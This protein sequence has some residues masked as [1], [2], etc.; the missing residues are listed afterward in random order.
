MPA[1]SPSSPT[2]TPKPFAPDLVEAPEKPSSRIC[3]GGCGGMLDPQF[4]PAA[5]FDSRIISG[6]NEWYFED[7]CDPCRERLEEAETEADKTKKVRQYLANTKI[8]PREQD[9]C[10][11]DLNGAG[12]DALRPHVSGFLMGRHNLFIFGKP[13]VGKS[14]PAAALLKAYIERHCVPGSFEEVPDLVDELRVAIREKKAEALVNSISH[15]GA[16]VLNDMGI[17]SPTTF[18]IERLHI[19]LDRWNRNKKGGLIIT[20]NLTL[21]ELAVKYDD[22]ITS[23]IFQSCRIV[24][25]VVGPDRRLARP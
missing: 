16:L 1:S 22:R 10:M 19:I 17:G 25:E 15:N 13:G 7:T 5:V 9:A 24:G 3:P 20:S 14:W 18:V 12:Q 11:E 2:N 6:T 21:D 23:R 8:A 4:I